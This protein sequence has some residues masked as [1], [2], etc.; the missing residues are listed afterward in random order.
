[1]AVFFKPSDINTLACSVNNM[2]RG[3]SAFAVCE[4]GDQVFIPPKIV[5]LV[6]IDVGDFLTAYCIDNFRPERD[7]EDRYAVRW[8][9]IRITVAERFNPAPVAAPAAPAPKPE[10]TTEQIEQ[11]ILTL[12]KEDRAFT[13]AQA[14]RDTGIDHM[15]VSNV[16]RGLHD[17]GQI[18]ACEITASG[19]QERVSK[20]YYA[21]DVD[22]LVDLIDE[23]LLDD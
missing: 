14:A 7:G 5:E 16:M 22:I 19:G 11:R 17:R 3:G 18:A 10:L 2:T 15:K 1:M 6:N 23:V 8:R 20:L 12:L 21:R 13:T 4:N 9:A